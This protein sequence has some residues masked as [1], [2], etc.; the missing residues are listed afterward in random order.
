MGNMYSYGWEAAKGFIRGMTGGLLN[1]PSAWEA[2]IGGI[3][4]GFTSMFVQGLTEMTKGTFDEIKIKMPFLSLLPAVAAQAF[5]RL[6]QWSPLLNCMAS[7]A[8]D[9]VVDQ[10]TTWRMAF[11]GNII[12]S[13]CS[14]VVSNF[15]FP[16]GFAGVVIGGMIGSVVKKRVSLATK[17]NEELAG[18]N[19][20]NPSSQLLLIQLC[21]ENRF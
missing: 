13:V 3:K 8:I 14:F 17:N 4:G 10:D 11:A 19:L 5:K 2:L 6:L 20:Q 9:G 1:G 21:T 16:G 12:K 7:T 15:I 18:K